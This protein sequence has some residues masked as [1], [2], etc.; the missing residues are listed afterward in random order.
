MKIDI[1][2]LV[3]VVIYITSV[4]SSYK[5][6]QKVFTKSDDPYKDGRWSN[7]DVDFGAILFTFIPI[8]NTI[9]AIITLFESPYRNSKKSNMGSR[10][11]SIFKVKK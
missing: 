5:W 2:L 3:L 6:F 11:N 1:S 7:L 4:Y 10:Y 9:V 8:A